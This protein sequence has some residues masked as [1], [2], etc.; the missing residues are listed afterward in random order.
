MCD[1]W[2]NFKN[3]IADMGYP[4]NKNLSIDRINNEGDYEPT[5]CRWATYSEQAKNTRA[6]KRTNSVCSEINI[7][8]STNSSIRDICSTLRISKSTIYRIIGHRQT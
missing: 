6:F 7:L 2:K 1:R 8:R 5:N 4:P 3:F